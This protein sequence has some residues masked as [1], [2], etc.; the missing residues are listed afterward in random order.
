DVEA[1]VG[2]GAKAPTL[3]QDRPLVEYLGRLDHLAV[4]GEECCVGEAS[5]HELE[6]DQSVVD[7]GESRASEIDDVD[8]DPLGVEAV[9]QR[10]DQFRGRRVEVKRT[11][12][13]VDA[14]YTERTLLAG[15][16]AVEQ[17]GVEDDFGRLRARS[18]LEAHAEPGVS[19]SRPRMACG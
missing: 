3:D 9:Q 19:L 13:Q 6:T 14:E 12:H 16:L 10:P 1:E 11:V 15:R 4:G 7:V 2:D 8:L 5:L 18:R 17:P